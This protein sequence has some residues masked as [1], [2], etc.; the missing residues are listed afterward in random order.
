MCLSS[1]AFY[2]WATQ[3]NQGLHRRHT[4]ELEPY[5]LDILDC[6]PES[7]RVEDYS[8]LLPKCISGSEETPSSLILEVKPLVAK[9]WRTEPDWAESLIQQPGAQISEEYLPRAL[10]DEPIKGL[11]KVAHLSPERLSAW[12]MARARAI[13]KYAGFADHALTLVEKAKEFNV[14]G[15]EGLSADLFALE[16]LVYTHDK[17]VG[18]LSLL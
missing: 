5:R 12:Y 6:I 17:H 4:C 2:F 9:P 8:S 7:A 15:L 11:N 16:H 18:S 3:S 13:D 14:P 1:L 10:R